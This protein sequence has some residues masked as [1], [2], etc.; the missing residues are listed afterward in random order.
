MRPL[1]GK[2]NSVLKKIFP[3]SVCLHEPS[4]EGREWE[5]VK[6]CLDTGWVS[7]AG[8]FVNTFEDK[9][10]IKRYITL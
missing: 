10:K 9:L 6:K 7:T 5:Y 2:I 8:S 4:F 3:E 1:A